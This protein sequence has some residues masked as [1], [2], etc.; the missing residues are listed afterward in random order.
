MI[1]KRWKPIMKTV[2][3]EDGFTMILALILLLLLTIIGVT[4]INT[5]TTGTMITS[6]EEV[7]RAASYVAESAV[8]TSDRRNRRTS[9]P[10][11]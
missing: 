5:S 7:K 6:A 10:I 3:N 11:H 2:N 9:D 1:R 4:A 8:E